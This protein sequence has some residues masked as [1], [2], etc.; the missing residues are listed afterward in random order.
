MDKKFVIAANGTNLV[1]INSTNIQMVDFNPARA[2]LM[3]KEQAFEVVK[4]LRLTDPETKYR[5]KAASQAYR[6]YCTKLIL[7]LDTAPAISEE[8]VKEFLEACKPQLKKS[9]AEEVD[10]AWE[11]MEK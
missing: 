8:G 7:S 6:D 5:V 3:S 1:N 2:T 11:G 10:K 9:A 4:V